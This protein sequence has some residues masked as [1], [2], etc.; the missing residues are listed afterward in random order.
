MPLSEAWKAILQQP[1]FVHYTTINAD[2]SPQTSPVWVA[3]DGDDL[4]VNSAA[5]RVKD[6]NVRRDPRVALSAVDPANPYHALMV[7]GRVVDI[8]TEGA[9]AQIDALAKKYLGQDK[10]PFRSPGE[11][12]VNYRIRPDKV[13]TMG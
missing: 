6:K 4:I 3:V 10:Y 1:V 12:R 11:V 8:S 2:G 13:S 7:R 5:G 9:D